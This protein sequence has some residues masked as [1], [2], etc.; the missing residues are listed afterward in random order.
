VL[1]GA[2]ASIRDEQQ[3][4]RAA[5]GEADPYVNFSVPDPAASEVNT[6]ASGSNN[7]ALLNVYKLLP[8]LSQVAPEVLQQLPWGAVFQL[9]L[10]LAKE[11]KANSKLQVNARLNANA[12]QLAQQPVHVQAGKDDRKDNLHPAHFL[13]GVCCSAQ[14]LWLQARDVIGVDGVLPLGLYDMDSI[15]CGGC[16]TPK[17]WHELHRPGSADLKLKL[18]SMMNVGSSSLSTKKVSVAD[19]EGAISVGDS[20]R[21]INDLEQFRAA[22]HTLHEAM[23]WALPWNKSISAIVGF[24]NVTGFG[25]ADL[26][27]NPKRAAILT[28]FVDH[29]LSRNRLNWENR[30]PFLSTDEIS[31]V[32][33]TYKGS[34]HALFAASS[35]QKKDKNESKSKKNKDKDYICRKFNSPA[36]CPQKAEDCKTFYGIKLKHVCDALTAAGKK[37]EQN[38][39]RMEHK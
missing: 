19:E 26:G 9:N 12:Q 18:F 23:A 37:C 39:T 27:G 6:P 33:A 11:S 31:H 13:G 4:S 16:V 30:R 25:S 20:W 14:S 1:T 10:A 7:Q 24:M 36:G 3:R 15:G 34:R 29:I 35:G 38:H 32:W 21:E 8:A 5:F 28:D 2:A 17:G 22:L